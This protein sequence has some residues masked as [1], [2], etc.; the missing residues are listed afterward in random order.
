MK[1]YFFIILLGLI[2]SASCLVYVPYPTEEGF[3]PE[4]EYYE[5]PYEEYPSGLDVSYF[6]DYL[7]PYG[8]WTYYR[9]YGYVWIPQDMLYGWR[10]YTRGHWVWTDH[11]WTWRSQV[12]WG[13]APFHYGRWGWDR[14]IGW[15]WAP[16]TIWGPGWVTWR[17]SDLYIGWAPLPPGAR[18]VA[19][20]GIRR[21]AFRI[22]SSHW[23]FVDGPYFLSP[24]L[25]LHVFPYE[26]N[27]TIINYTVHK[28][29]IYVRNNRV[30]N[31]G[32]S[33]DRVRRITKQNI[34]KHELK[35]TNKAELRR[36]GAG[37]LEV[38]RPKI[39]KSQT[40]KPKAVLRK[41]EAKE[42]I[43]KARILKLEKGVLPLAREKR[44]R[45]VHEREVKLLERSQ[46]KEMKELERKL[47]ERKKAVRTQ[48][49]KKKVERAYK[50]EVI[51]LQKS[52]EAEKSEI[53]K[54]HKEEEEKAKKKEPKKKKI[55]KKVKK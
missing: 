2:F 27:I 6:Y 21:L 43:S 50:E 34:L 52:H 37:K 54:R 32:V 46:Q 3:P 38:Y 33:F 26:R 18:F 19:G 13:W 36:I 28:T 22:P 20:I 5:E 39:R 1:K 31:E 23:V 45:E 25:H 16:G 7:S 29:N 42:R 35:D 15:F 14:D 55:K 10:P 49:E 11:G 51:K 17:S 41:Q 30:V 4:E 12:I 9:P 24:S 53:K 40:A 47:E 48:T 8:I 44:I